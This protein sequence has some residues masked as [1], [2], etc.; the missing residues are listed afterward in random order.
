VSRTA[1]LFFPPE[2]DGIGSIKTIRSGDLNHKKCRQLSLSEFGLKV[3][4]LSAVSIEGNA[5]VMLLG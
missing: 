3:E 2:R 1:P 5:L 4:F